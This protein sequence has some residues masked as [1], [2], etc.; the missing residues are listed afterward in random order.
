MFTRAR[1]VLATW[2][3]VALLVTLGAIGSAAYILIRNDIDNEINDS[4]DATRLVV[5]QPQQTPD[6]NSDGRSP[7]NPTGNGNNV[8]N[9]GS[10]DDDY[11]RL[12]PGVPADVFL[13]Y[14]D[15]SGTV[16]GN[17]RSIDID[18]VDFAKLTAAAD[19]ERVTTDVHSDGSHFRLLTEQL[20]TSGIWIHIGRSL[21]ARDRQLR[22]LTTVFLVG[23]L[24]GLVA[25]AAG[26]LWL[27]GVALRPIRVSYE[28]QQRFVSDASH[29]LRTPLAVL[30]ANSE[31]LQRHPEDTIAR[32]MEQVDAITEE[33]ESMTKLVEDLLLLARAD[34]GAANL[35]HDPVA[36][37]AL[38]EELGRKMEPL[39][40]ERQILLRVDAEPVEVDG[41]R[42]RLRQLGTILLD[43]A[44]KYTQPGGRV[45]LKC[46]QSGKWVELSVADTGPGIPTEEQSKIFDRFVRA[47]SARTRATGGAGLGLA[48]AKWIAEA[49]GG[50]ISVESEPG[51]GAKFTV[52]LPALG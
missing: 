4:L 35:A 3:S 14:T 10:D 29:E 31:L 39:A 47:D 44:L 18:E 49:H 19:G 51:N 21:E 25:A 7:R 15:A 9:S 37:G 6:R 5:E 12:P 33:A 11:D 40:G 16:Y 46:T 20:G 50:R 32:N 38:V 13:I 27:A 24:G 45:D 8:S 30:R 22:T 36:L 17:P 48:I 52:R 2:F 1:F 34:E 26:G 43:N 42:A 28:R 23:G 41:D